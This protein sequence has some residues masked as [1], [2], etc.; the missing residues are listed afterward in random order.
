MIEK[1]ERLA[2]AGIQLL[3]ALE[4]TTHYLVERDGF[5]ALIERKPDDGFGGIG[6]PG[7]WTGHGLAPLVWRG[8]I[9]FFIAKGFEQPAESHQ[10]E[11][12]RR[13]QSDLKQA[14]S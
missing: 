11:S 9:P 7:L 13:F 5:V 3:P 10:V 8:D 6:A 12:V 1:L 4:I 2:A 14:L